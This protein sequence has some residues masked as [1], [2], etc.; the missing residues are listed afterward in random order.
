MVLW[1]SRLSCMGPSFGFLSLV[2][3]HQIS[4]REKWFQLFQRIFHEKKDPKLPDFEG[5]KIPNCLIFMISSSR[6]SRT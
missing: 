4:T 3:F 1:T 5:K 2:N 6:E